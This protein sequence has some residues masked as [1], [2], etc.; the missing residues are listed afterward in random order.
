MVVRE[1]FGQRKADLLPVAR[2]LGLDHHLVA[3]PAGI[4]NTKRQP[5][6]H[7]A[8]D[9]ERQ[10]VDVHTLDVRNRLNIATALGEIAFELE[11]SLAVALDRRINGNPAGSARVTLLL[12]RIASRSSHC[13]G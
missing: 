9:P 4:D 6:L 7:M 1:E 5:F 10:L 12:C 2:G 8:P 13:S 11:A 3:L